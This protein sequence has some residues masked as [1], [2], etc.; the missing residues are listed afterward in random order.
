MKLKTLLCALL[1]T[2]LPL[3]AAAKVK[4]VTSTTDLAYYAQKIGGELIEVTSIASPT[5]DLHYVEVRPSY[6][7]KMRDADLAL[8]VGLELDMWMTRLVDGSRNNKLKVIDCSKYIEPMEVPSFKPDASYGDLHRFGN[9]HYW[10]SPDN[11]EP[12]TRAILDGLT[13]IDP[14][15]AETFTAN[16][17]KFL[18]EV[19]AQL[20]EIKKLALP[21]NGQE[22]VTYHNS[23]PYFAAYFGLKLPIFIEKY[24]GVAPSPTHILDVIEMVKGDQINLLAMEP[25][26]DRRIPNK[27]ASATGAKVVTLYPSIGGRDKNESY[28]DW[29]REN[30]QAL[31]DAEGT[32]K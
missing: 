11:L 30:V 26:F 20:P 12:I 16:R 14:Q 24:P 9:P 15:N 23:W 29:L 18:S 7:V 31:L 6:M 21:L 17:D 32:S 19:Y 10:M 4:L 28:I 13:E 22:V 5:A 2:S 1:V 25:Y 27:I 8:K 3:V